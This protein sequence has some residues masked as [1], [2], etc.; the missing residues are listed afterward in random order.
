M[1]ISNRSLPYAFGCCLWTPEHLTPLEAGW[2]RR[3][4][5]RVFPRLWP[6]LSTPGEN[7]ALV[8]TRMSHRTGS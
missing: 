3:I 8:A 2:R 1:T 4:Y 6:L 7:V 5:E